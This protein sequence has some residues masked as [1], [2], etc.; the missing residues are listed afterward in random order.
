VQI[1]V[2]M[3]A[4]TPVD[5]G[6]TCALSALGGPG[7]VTGECAGAWLAPQV[8]SSP[9][10]APALG[11]VAAV[12]AGLRHLS[13]PDSDTVPQEAPAGASHTGSPSPGPAPGGAS[14]GSSGAGSGGGA[15][16]SLTLGCLL[17]LA[18]PRA[19][20]RLRLA[21]EPWLTSFFV[22]IPERPG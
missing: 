10:P 16:L 14:G 13:I 9:A 22:L 15:S 18:A 6:S 19:L 1:S 3:R 7:P 11:G 2:S 4:G 17:L 12:I 5:P 21:C 8:G 20:R